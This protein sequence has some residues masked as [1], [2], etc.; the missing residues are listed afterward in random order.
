MVIRSVIVVPG[1][2]S[3]IV[4]IIHRQIVLSLR[5]LIGSFVVY[6]VLSRLE[7]KI[8]GL[9]KKQVFISGTLPELI[10]TDEV[11]HRWIVVN[12]TDL[13]NTGCLP[14]TNNQRIVSRKTERI[15]MHPVQF[16]FL[17]VDGVKVLLKEIR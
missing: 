4:V 7:S 6:A 2:D 1:T 8:A 14:G 13:D 17:V 15:D 9:G 3:S 16:V 12:A 10:G 11:I 5:E